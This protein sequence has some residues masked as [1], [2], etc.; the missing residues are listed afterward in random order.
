MY[1][2]VKLTLR[3]FGTVKTQTCSLP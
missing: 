3:L 1:P 2:Y